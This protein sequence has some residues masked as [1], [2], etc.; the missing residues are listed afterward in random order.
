MLQV[1]LLFIILPLLWLYPHAS[2]WA[3]L[4]ELYPDD[5][6]HSGDTHRRCDVSFGFMRYRVVLRV[7]PEGL[8]MSVPWPFSTRLLGH[9]P[10]L[11]PWSQFN[12]A[13]VR[14]FVFPVVD[15]SIG[16]PVVAHVTLPVWLREHLGADDQPPRR[17][18]AEKKG[19]RRKRQRD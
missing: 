19:S 8:G 17:K 14:G 4:A 3:K 6:Q 5:G 2:G 15:T 18:R 7:C 11:I 9:P 12:K 13:T 10:L 16:R 1:L